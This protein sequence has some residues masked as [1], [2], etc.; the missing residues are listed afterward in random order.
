[1]RSRAT[2]FALALALPLLGASMVGC[3]VTAEPIPTVVIVGTEPAATLIVDWTIE[4]RAD[5]RDCALS[6]A[7]SIEITVVADSGF[8]AGTF[9]QDCAAFSTSI[10]LAPGT[11]AASAQLVDIA[12]VPRTT[13]VTLAPFTLFRNDQL[14]VPVDFPAD[15]FF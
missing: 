5:P 9:V 12:G 10:P 7:A 6:G 11:Y 13:A 8:D 14:V 4:L 2:T 15:S 1:M 3:T